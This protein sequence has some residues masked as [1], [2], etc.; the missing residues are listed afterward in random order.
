MIGHTDPSEVERIMRG[1]HEERSDPYHFPFLQV[2]FYSC[3]IVDQLLMACRLVIQEGF[4]RHESQAIRYL[5]TGAPADQHPFWV[6]PGD[7]WFADTPE[8]VIGHYQMTLPPGHCRVRLQTPGV[9]VAHQA[10][11]RAACRQPPTWNCS[12]LFPSGGT[13]DRWRAIP[14]RVCP[15]GDAPPNE[16]DGPPRYSP[17]APS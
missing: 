14:I 8:P 16:G 7:F 17:T 10:R 1:F 11:G 5:V 13:P 9:R 3:S 6:T 4:A 12:A 15:G 2:S